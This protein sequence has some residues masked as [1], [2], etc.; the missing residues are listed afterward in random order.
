MPIS[1]A[2][3][4][5]KAA[6]ISRPEAALLLSSG[7]EA[8]RSSS[9]ESSTWRASRLSIFA[10]F[11]AASE[12]DPTTK[13]VRLAKPRALPPPTLS[14]E[15]FTPFFA[16]M[17]SGLEGASTLFLSRKKLKSQMPASTAAWPYTSPFTMRYW[18]TL[19]L[20]CEAFKRRDAKPSRA[21]TPSP[22]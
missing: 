15:R 13:D 5:S 16:D 4:S 14:L 21:S 10:I 19:P 20:S 22:I 3:P 8:L 7:T 6:D 1:M 12:R 11:S 9:S 18:G 2:V 17:T